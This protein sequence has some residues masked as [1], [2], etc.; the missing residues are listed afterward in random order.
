[1]TPEQLEKNARDQD[2][3][4]KRAVEAP[5][6]GRMIAGRKQPY[7]ENGVIVFDAS[8]P[9]WT[10]IGI[11]AT[12]EF[13]L[14]N[15]RDE[16]DT[17]AYCQCG[18]DESS[19]VAYSLHGYAVDI[20]CDYGYIEAR[21]EGLRWCPDE[22]RWRWIGHPQ[23]DACDGSGKV[24]GKRCAAA[25]CDAGTI[26]DDDEDA[27]S[28]WCEPPPVPKGT[29]WQGTRSPCALAEEREERERDEEARERMGVAAPRP[30]AQKVRFWKLRIAE[31]CAEFP[32]CWW[33]VADAAALAQITLT[34]DDVGKIARCGEEYYAAY[35]EQSVP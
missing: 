22:G 2:R 33:E 24:A 10:P 31:G 13:A 35:F 12:L 17:C 26:D 7:V 19:W 20:L 1:M 8:D 14:R 3:R 30:P 9:S 34:K 4:Q 28:W 15:A 16:R 27:S 21:K 32:I 11:G 25:G 6:P 29:I 23:C 18:R 5:Y